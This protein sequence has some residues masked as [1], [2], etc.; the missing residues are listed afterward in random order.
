[1]R[2]R[3]ICVYHEREEPYWLVLFDRNT[4]RISKLY[5]SKVSTGANYREVLDRV[6]QKFHELTQVVEVKDNDNLDII[7][8]IRASS[9]RILQKR[10]S[11]FSF[12]GWNMAK[13]ERI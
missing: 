10:L 3:H 7:F 1:M 11:E 9:K 13:I 4:R 2:E 6:A 12:R 5:K 8:N